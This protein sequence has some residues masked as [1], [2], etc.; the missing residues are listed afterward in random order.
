MEDYF[1]STNNMTVRPKYLDAARRLAPALARRDPRRS[2]HLPPSG[3]SRGSTG[4]LQARSQWGGRSGGVASPAPLNA[5]SSTA[6]AHDVAHSSVPCIVFTSSP[7]SPPAFIDG[8]S[9]RS[10]PLSDSFP[11]ATSTTL[12]PFAMAFVPTLVAAPSARPAAVPVTCRSA[13]TGVAVARAA[14][15]RPAAMT[16]NSIQEKIEVEVAK[17][18]EASE[19]YGKT[20]KEAAAAWYVRDVDCASGVEGVSLFLVW[21]RLCLC[22]ILLEWRVIQG[23]GGAGEGRVGGRPVLNTLPPTGPSLSPSP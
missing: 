12:P 19:K 21:N 7:V 5:R 14:V 3:Q 23:R 18:K 17:A 2:V 8:V 15:R 6:T 13:F 11:S 22:V 4:A 9:P 16:M 1:Q 20:S 10:S